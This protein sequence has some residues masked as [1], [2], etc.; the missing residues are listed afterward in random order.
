MLFLVRLGLSARACPCFFALLPH[1]V[2]S[3][4]L[5]S[6]ST[7]YSYSVFSR[8]SCVGPRRQR[9][10]ILRMVL[11]DPTTAT[12]TPIAHT[13]RLMSFRRHRGSVYDIEKL[14]RPAKDLCQCPQLKTRSPNPNTVI[15]KKRNTARVCM[16]KFLSLAMYSPSS[17]FGA[18]VLSL[19]AGE[20]SASPLF[21]QRNMC[22]KNMTTSRKKK[23]YN[24]N[25]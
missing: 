13:N 20:N 23:I 19:I 16:A 8:A 15:T 22:N 17:C 6:H 3:I 21:F 24:T 7:S 25:A 12:I 4:F 18:F 11:P 10:H 14:V 2:Y 1:G 9:R 5:A